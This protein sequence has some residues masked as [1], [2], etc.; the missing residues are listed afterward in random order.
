M[1]SV[2]LVSVVYCSMRHGKVGLQ[3]GADQKYY[4]SRCEKKSIQLTI[5]MPVRDD[6][7]RGGC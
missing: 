2:V 1:V 7:K 3:L 4:I 5:T 6:V